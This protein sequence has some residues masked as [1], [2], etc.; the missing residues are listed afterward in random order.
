MMVAQSKKYYSLEEYLTLDGTDGLKYEYLSGEIYMMAGASEAH[1][2]ISG[3]IHA[4]FHSQLRQQPRRAYNSDMRVKTP[5]NQFSYPDVTVVC[6]DRSF[7]QDKIATL[8]NPTLL[9]EV[10]SET[11][12]DFDRG[13]KFRHYRTLSS[14]REYVVVDTDAA[15]I[16]HYTR[17]GG[18]RWLLSEISGLDAALALDS[19]GCTL[20]LADVYENITLPPHA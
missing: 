2:V 14:L 12:R 3:N 15:R 8:L 10:L 5:T 11:T 7:T 18:D 4:A 1:I 19:I 16:E 6:G 9:V 20:A 13:E 17:Q